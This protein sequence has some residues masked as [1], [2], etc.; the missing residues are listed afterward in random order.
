MTRHQR[1]N[2]LS[3]LQKQ[4]FRSQAE[5]FL[6]HIRPMMRDLKAFGPR[7]KAL[8]AI[9]RTIDASYEVL[10][11]HKPDRLRIGQTSTPGD[12]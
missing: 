3:E 7:D 8:L 2:S 10:D 4:A 11:I 6:H 5:Q 12:E 9:S 1:R